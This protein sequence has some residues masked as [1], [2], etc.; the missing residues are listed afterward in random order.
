MYNYDMN[1]NAFC[2]V[3]PI[4]LVI[5]DLD[6]VITNTSVFHYLAWKKL[7]SRL[8]IRIDTDFN[9]SLKGVSRMESLERI[10]KHGSMEAKFSQEE[11]LEMASEKN[12]VYV[13]ML[14][15]IT[16]DSILGGIE[17]LL[18]NL[19][20]LNIKTAVASVSENAPFIL[21]R[22]HITDK[23]DYIVNP[24]EV[25]RSKPFP[26]IFLR[27]AQEFDILPEYCVGIEDAESGIHSIN[28]AGMF[29]VGVGEEQSMQKAYMILKSTYELN[30]LRIRECYENWFSKQKG[31]S[32]NL[33]KF[34]IG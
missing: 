9:E 11:K 30:F 17:N 29:S 5:F 25:A 21:N 7:A 34:N 24:K 16:P 33:H 22:L 1:E 4:K 10:L 2:E 15:N 13:R 23:F 28:S 12:D 31:S 18:E 14:E 19:K 26:D 20:E 6:G 3:R 32:I 27:A 8:G